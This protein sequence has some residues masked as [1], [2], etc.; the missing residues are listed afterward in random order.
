[1]GASLFVLLL[2]LLPFKILVLGLLRAPM[3][4]RRRHW[5]RVL[6][7]C[8]MQLTGLQFDGRMFQCVC[9]E[10]VC[11]RVLVVRYYVIIAINLLSMRNIHSF[12][13]KFHSLEHENKRWMDQITWPSHTAS[14]HILLRSHQIC[15]CNYCLS[16]VGNEEIPFRSTRYKTT[17][18]TQT[19][20]HH[21]WFTP[22]LDE[23]S[24]FVFIFSRY[25]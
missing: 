10:C 20:T 9:C 15:L 2:L 13:C 8:C 19:H 23:T 12:A 1:M 24:F 6:G 5:F 7:R 4:R 22:K 17:T 21:N 18:P 16:L 3:H 25:R 11:V 14:Q